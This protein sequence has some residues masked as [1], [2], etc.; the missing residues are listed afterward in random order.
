MISC[1]NSTTKPNVYNIY[2]TA[3]DLLFIRMRMMASRI[4]S[5]NEDTH[6]TTHYKLLYRNHDYRNQK[7]KNQ[8]EKRYQCDT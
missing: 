4:V 6:T 3:K 7:L 5:K 8:A 1:P 2:N